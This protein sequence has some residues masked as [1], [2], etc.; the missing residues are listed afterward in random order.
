M[1]CGNW[2]TF[3]LVHRDHWAFQEQLGWKERKEKGWEASAIEHYPRDYTH[4]AALMCV[5][6][7]FNNIYIFFF[8]QGPAGQAGDD[9]ERGPNVSL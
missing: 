3:A 2:L 5:R 9:G 4:P 7:F 8:W 6:S 1:E